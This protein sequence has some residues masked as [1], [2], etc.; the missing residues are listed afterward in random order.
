[1]NSAATELGGGTK[2]SLDEA[3]FDWQVLATIVAKFPNYYK[4]LLQKYYNDNGNDLSQRMLFC[5]DGQLLHCI[6]DSSVM[7]LVKKEATSFKLK[8]YSDFTRI[9]QTEKKLR[10]G[11]IL[12]QETI[13]ESSFGSQ[14][15]LAYFTK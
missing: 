14:N 5:D 6:R 8:S 3:I 11:Y 4:D 13:L 1:M 10:E 9:I 15:K 7:S 12:Y 2:N